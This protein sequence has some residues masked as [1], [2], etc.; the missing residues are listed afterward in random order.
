[1]DPQYEPNRDDLDPVDTS[2]ARQPALIRW[3]PVFAGAVIAV[4][5]FVLA[6]AF[7]TALAYG[8]IGGADGAGVNVQGIADNLAWYLAASAVAATFVGGFVSGWFA[9]LR[10]WGPGLLSGLTMWSVAIVGVVLFGA[11]SL[12]GVFGLGN[13]SSGDIS[14]NQMWAAFWG[15]LIGLAAS[16]LG[17]LLG[18][19]VQRPVALFKPQAQDLRTPPVRT[20]RGTRAGAH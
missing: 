1:M 20:P 8:N 6:S 4:G 10:G 12:L 14:F 9:G 2:S 13:F 3:G 16:L 11:P 15:L 19:A 18:G 17:G 7:W 5:L